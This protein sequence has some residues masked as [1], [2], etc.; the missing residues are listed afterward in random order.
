MGSLEV[1][2]RTDGAQLFMQRAVWKWLLRS[3]SWKCLQPGLFLARHLFLLQRRHGR[4]E[5]SSPPPQPRESLDRFRVIKHMPVERCAND[6]VIRT[7]ARRTRL[8]RTITYWVRRTAARRQTRPTQPSLRAR[9]Q[10]VAEKS[11]GK[12]LTVQKLRRNVSARAKSRVVALLV[13]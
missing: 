8:P 13:E 3:G 7:V 11:L 1:T 9:H 2:S 4:C 10:S 5:V 6:T 12:D